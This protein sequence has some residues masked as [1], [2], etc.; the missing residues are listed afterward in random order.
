MSSSYPY[1]S[2]NDPSKEKKN[3]RDSD[4]KVITHPPNMLVNPQSKITY[5]QNKKF[6]YVE[7]PPQK[8]A[9][10]VESTPQ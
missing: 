3:Y 6:K 1:M 9:K 4:G 5:Q 8:R 10:T 2:P 7:S